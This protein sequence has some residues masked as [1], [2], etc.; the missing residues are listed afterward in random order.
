[1]RD[2]RAVSIRSV[3]RWQRIWRGELGLAETFW[4]Y[5]VLALVA[6]HFV[7]QFALIELALWGARDVLALGLVFLTLAGGYQVLVSVGAWRAAGRYSGPR[8]FALAARVAVAGSLAL[9]AFGVIRAAH[10]ATLDPVDPER[11]LA[12]ATKELRKNPAYPLGGIWKRDC[13]DAYG[14][15]IEPAAREGLYAVTLCGPAGCF[16]PGAFRPD[17]PIAG[18]SAYRVLDRDTLAVGGRDGFSAYRRCE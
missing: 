6:L 18:D 2:R 11:S 5:G 16:R 15:V 3:N 4:L 8:A 1:M 9:L 17:T 13:G 12:L 7:G 10:F 14:M